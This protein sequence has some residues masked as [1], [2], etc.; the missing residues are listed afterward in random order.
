ME[1]SPLRASLFPGL[2]TWPLILLSGHTPRA[3]HPAAPTHAESPAQNQ[4]QTVWPLGIGEIHTG[5]IS[6]V[7]AVKEFLQKAPAQTV[8]YQLH[9]LPTVAPGY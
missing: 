2:R 6:Q 8:L 3:L 1:R 7:W 4:A 5:G 9:P